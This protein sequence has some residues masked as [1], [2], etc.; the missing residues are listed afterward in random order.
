MINILVADNDKP[1]LFLDL[2]PM[3]RNRPEDFM[4]NKFISGALE[5]G[6]EIEQGFG[7]HYYIKVK[8]NDLNA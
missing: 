7:G 5:K 1:Y 6:L 8:G 3:S 2:D 4:L